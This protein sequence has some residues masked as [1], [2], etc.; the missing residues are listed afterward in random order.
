MLAGRGDADEKTPTPARQ[1]RAGRAAAVRRGAG[2]PRVFRIG[3]LTAQ[4]PP[5]LVPYV[6]AFRTSLA[7][8]GFVEGKNLT[9][10][11]RYGDDDIGAR[12]AA[13]PTSWFACRS[14]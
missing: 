14:T 4:R 7:E 11:F 5:S 1:R 2:A 9:I 6:Q 10:E 8:L 12:C 3:W 13:S